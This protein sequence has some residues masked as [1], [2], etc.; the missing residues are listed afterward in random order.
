M[1]TVQGSHSATGSAFGQRKNG[2]SSI[3]IRRSARILITF[4]IVGSAFAACSGG[5]SS[6]GSSGT[7]T[8]ATASQ[9]VCEGRT[10]LS[11]AVSNLA[12]DLR[13]GNFS[14]AKDD[15]PAVRDALDSLST[16]AQ[17]LK[18]EE[19]HA[20]SPQ[21]DALKNSIATLKNS[22]S[23]SDLQSGFH[24]IKAQAQSIS[25]QIEGTLKCS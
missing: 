10:Q 9:K 25:S 22:S 2:E 5:S 19:S 11:S 21:I 14:K 12:D 24:S 4:V 17:D 6:G 18:S 15:L 8:P 1:Q 23:L 3:P 16:S 13:A 20:L 7:S